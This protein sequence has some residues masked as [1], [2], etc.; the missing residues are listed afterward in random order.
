[1]LKYPKGETVWVTFLAKGRPVYIIT[2]KQARELYYLY[3]IE[4][5][6]LVKIE[7][8]ASPETLDAIAQKGVAECMKK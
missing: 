3:K 5:D 6:K 1:M 2:S 4:E 7:K 8:S